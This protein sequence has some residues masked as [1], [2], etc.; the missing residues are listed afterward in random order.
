MHSGRSCKTIRI[1]RH[2]CD[3]LR[4]PN[5]E[6]VWYMT[7]ILKTQTKNKFVRICSKLEDKLTGSKPKQQSY[8]MADPNPDP[9]DRTFFF[10]NPYSKDM[11]HKTWV[12]DVGKT[13]VQGSS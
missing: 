12:V 2:Y 6:Q 7:Q 1:Y 8:L 9:M 5:L 3:P 11:I 13:Q 4:E 10:S